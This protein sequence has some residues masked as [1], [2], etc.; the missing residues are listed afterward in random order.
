MTRVSRRLTSARSGVV[1]EMNMP[2][3]LKAL[4]GFNA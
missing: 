2:E 4:L 3:D 1:Y